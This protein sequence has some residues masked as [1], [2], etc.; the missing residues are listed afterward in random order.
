MRKDAYSFRCC[1]LEQVFLWESMIK[2]VHS[3][4]RVIRTAESHIK[5]FV[6]WITHKTLEWKIPS[7]ILEDEKRQT[8][9]IVSMQK[10][11]WVLST[12]FLKDKCDWKPSNREKSSKL[13]KQSK[14]KINILFKVFF[15]DF[16]NYK[17]SL[18]TFPLI[19]R[20]IIWQNPASFLCNALLCFILSH[21]LTLELLSS[22][23]ENWCWQL[24]YLDTA[25]YIAL[26]KF[27]SK[28]LHL[29][30][31]ERNEAKAYKLHYFEKQTIR[32][33]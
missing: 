33:I 16:W 32:M 24:L 19:W 1:K 6:I 26:I 10:R 9:T 2:C 22:Q 11:N 18:Q 31:I 25:K 8:K 5:S 29:S 13:I 12:Y 28:R 21:I 27:V 30:L 20:L 17:I 4:A 14:S 3:I 15:N 7:L 23:R